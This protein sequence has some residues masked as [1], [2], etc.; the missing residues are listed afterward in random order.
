[1]NY[2]VTGATGFIGRHLMPLLLQRGATVY[3]L[4]REASLA[5]L[6]ELR[7]AWGG[8][9]RVV[10]VPG[11]L[12]R[13]C[14]GVDAKL[15]S[16][17][18]GC[19]DQFFHLAALYDMTA[20]ASSLA[21]ANLE[22]TRNAL[23]L[24]G[25]LAAGRFNHVSS[26]AVAG[27][28]PGIFREDMFDEAE[29]LDDPYFRSKHESEGLVRNERA[30]PWR[31][32]RPGI[33]VGHSQSGEMDK[34]DGP[35]YFF[36]LLQK[37]RRAFP[38]WFPLIGIDGAP[39]NLVPVDF[40]AAAIDHLAHA[41]G[42]DGRAFHLVDAAP[43][44]L[45]KTMNIFARAAHGP[46]FGLK[47]DAKVANVVPP[48]LRKGLAHLPPV[49]RITDQVLADLGI[50]RRVLSYA[51]QTTR[52]D[53]TDTRRALEG[54]GLEV[55][56]LESYAYRLWDYWERN[57]DP[58]LHRDRS[59]A[60]AVRGKRVLISGASSGI[61]RAAARKIG[62]AGGIVHLVARSADKLESVKSE[63]ENAGGTAHVHTA[64][65]S[66]LNSCD[67]LVAEIVDKHGGIDVLINN[68]G[69]SIRRSLALSEQRF[70]DFERTMQ[71]NYF[72]ALKLIMGFVPGMRERAGGHIINISSLGVQTNPPRFSAY[73]ASKAALDAFSRCAA[74]ELVDHGIAITTVF[75][76]LV[77]TDM[78]A[79][80]KIY[81]AFPTR[82][83]EE[84][85]DLICEA[86]IE[87]PKR[88]STRL[89]IFGEIAYAAAPKAV[90]VVLNAAYKLFPDSAASRGDKH[91]DAE[92]M[93][94]E[95][96]AF[97]HLIPG[98]HW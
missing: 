75:M 30:C 77:K 34:I 22:G 2:F 65:L 87:R 76:P 78:I 91:D 37:L 25:A 94:S 1:M 10:P 14:L 9:K 92:E 70:H 32:Y 58:D 33:V 8:D 74:S 52:F 48:A 56:D 62:E 98:V 16:R 4:V 5:H 39:M 18:K 24:A 23:E 29:G 55:P 95:A 31:V 28:Y 7:A 45:G 50:P 59:L 46:E 36:K 93:T 27:R 84:A 57:L 19:V 44:S 26:I 90:D 54:S 35:Y 6:D 66:D 67:A 73:V 60:G 38:Q 11:D 97:A 81:E 69:R 68:A 15:R 88:V 80:T 12:A 89:G 41:D 3:V 42:L 13:P 86:I 47:L 83:P 71:L 53:C 82:T 40:V 64:D 96:V 49:R 79:P 63:I 72:G 43:K 20:D 61:G 51:S 17:L 21:Q 85:A